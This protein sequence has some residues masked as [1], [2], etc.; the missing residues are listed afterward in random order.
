MGMNKKY[1]LQCIACGHAIDD[2]AQWFS[3][4]QK[5]PKCGSIQADV[6]YYQDFDNLLALIRS[7]NFKPESLWGYFDFLPLLNRKNIVSYG[8]EG[9]VPIERWTF[10]EHFAKQQYG[11]T[12]KVY[13]HRHDRNHATGTFKDLAGTS[14]ASILKEN[15]IQN[16]VGASTGNIGNAYA[17]YLA[18]AGINLYLF[19]PESSLKSQEA[20]VSSYGQRVFRVA[21]DYHEA[22]VAAKNFAQKHNFLLTGGNFDPMRLEAKKTMLYEWLRLLPDFPTVFMQAISG[23]SGP[24]GVAKSCRELRDKNVFKELPRFI[25]PQPHRCA[26]MADAWKEAKAK[27]FPQ[28]WE[29]EYPIIENPETTINTLATGNPNAYPALAPIVKESRGEIMACEEEKTIDV[30]RLAGYETGLRPGPAAAITLVG[31]FQALREGSITEGD[32]VMLNIGEGVARSPKFVESLSYTAETVTEI[33]DI[34]LS[35]RSALRERLY[36]AV[37][38]I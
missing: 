5:C 32:V 6:M 35:N 24:I 12:I 2:F 17:C 28:G 3:I 10:L 23:G 20:E 4:G 21:G 18:A 22:K 37:A 36:E 9:I 13:A 31:F 7:K 1:Y 33:N 30:V 15:G 8:G 26:P 34:K 11:R 29:K 19:I 14:A 16:Y 27:G 25:L 38:K